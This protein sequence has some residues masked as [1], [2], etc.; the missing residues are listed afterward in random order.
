MIANNSYHFEIPG[1]KIIVIPTPI[2]SISSPYSNLN[3][4]D[5]QNQFQQDYV[6]WDIITDNSQAR[7]Q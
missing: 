7:L 2:S 3:N 1:F 4:L 6:P 5:M